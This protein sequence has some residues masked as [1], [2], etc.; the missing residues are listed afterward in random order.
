MDDGD[1]NNST[2]ENSI[3]VVNK[4]HRTPPR[5]VSL[6]QQ[7]LPANDVSVFNKNPQ[8]PPKSNTSKPPA[9]GR[10]VS[11][12]SNSPPNRSRSKSKSSPKVSKGHRSSSVSTNR[13]RTNS[14][15]TVNKRKIHNTSQKDKTCAV[16]AIMYLR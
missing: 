4:I 2:G 13:D 15:S 14:I 12:K 8:T 3:I 10:N 7:T 5:N 6:S 11:K 1:V 16:F 9:D